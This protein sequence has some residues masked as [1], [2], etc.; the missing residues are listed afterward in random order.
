[1]NLSKQ[2]QLRRS[3][4]L[5]FAVGAVFAL[6]THAAEEGKKEK[7]TVELNKVEVTG[8]R[9]RRVDKEKA[10]PVFTMTRA[11]IEKSSAV[12][13]GQLLQ[14]MPSISGAATNPQVNN[15]GGTGGATVSLRG[16][17]S[18]R[19]LILLDGRRLVTTDVNAIPVNLIERVE[20][21]KDG[22]SAIYGADAVAGV[23]NFITRKNY[24]GA[25]LGS[26]YGIHQ[27]KDGEL[28]SLFATY[29]VTG[30]K[31]SIMVGASF[32]DREGVS[33][34]DRELPS[35]PR[36]LYYGQEVA[37]GSS[38]V[39]NGRYVVSCASAMAAGIVTT[40]PVTATNPNPTTALIRRDGAAGNAFNAA[41]FR[42]FVGGGP[43]NDTFN[44]QPDNLVLTPQQ[45]FGTFFKADYDMWNDASI[46]GINL[47]SAKVYTDALYHNTQS[48]F[49]IA[50]APFDGRPAFDNVPIS[51]QSV[52]NPF[53]QTIT[54][55]RLRLNSVGR[56]QEFFDINRLQ[57][58]VGSK[59]TIADNFDWEI[60]HTF[61]RENFNSQSR[62]D[63]FTGGLRTALGPSFIAADG[64]PTCGTPSAPIS[65]CTPINFVGIPDPAA[66][67]TVAPI[68]KFA[69]ESRLRNTVFNVANSDL[70]KLP[71][72]SV[73]AA[74][75]MEFRTV[76]LRE[77]PDFLR[78]NGLVSGNAQSPIQ[79]AFDVKEY[80][81]EVNVPVLAN[82]PFAKSLDLN[83]GVRVSD[84]SNFGETTNA[85]FGFEYRPY[86]DLLIRGTYADV[87]RA[88]TV[89]DLFSG[90]NDSADSAVDP[91]NGLTAATVA[92]NP[93]AARA[94]QNVRTDGTF[95]Q[96]DSQLPARTGGNP[97]LKPE[98]GDTQTVGFVYSPSF[99]PKVT[100]IMDYW[101]FN[102][103]DTIDTPGTENIL[104]AC[105][106]AGQFCDAIT[107]DGGGDVSNV[108]N[109]ISNIGET[110]TSGIDTSIAWNIGKV[111]FGT[112]N[113]GNFNYK[114]DTTY[115]MK[116]KNQ[117]VV[118]VPETLQDVPGKFIEASAGGLGN[119]A[120]VR[121]QQALT[122]RNGD[123]SARYVT[124]YI[125]AVNENPGD[126]GFDPSAPC[127]GNVQASGAV[128]ERKVERMFYHDIS[129]SYAFKPA[130]AELTFGIDNVANEPAPLVYSGF[131]GST[132][133]RTYNTTGRFYYGKV[134]FSFK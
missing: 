68:T 134:K 29:G 53:G 66:L 78:V 63:V 118:G 110:T 100:L 43:G 88:P 90:Q 59:G 25:E 133:A 89:A 127:I 61:G 93:N 83:A 76:D 1:M 39:P 26:S 121:A 129:T 104:N 3:I 108:F 7:K 117:Q 97:N 64:T 132:D 124:R 46:A 17:G 40:C 123:F 45:R 98:T 34:G 6:P 87:F 96:S 70:I 71:A 67:A 11:D 130:K 79:G 51:A 13:L 42:P 122:W 16:L 82:V 60:F 10:A 69:S 105:F 20:V 19:T 91:C 128:C 120:R 4:Y 107:R 86:D 14:E 103:E 114:L 47:G 31:G 37:F 15:G 30:E 52:F 27:R 54:D 113:V 77:T 80:F 33:A 49:Q 57:I 73:G 18:A 23:V 55:S 35:I 109:T 99:Y 72:G 95:R 85:K 22:A 28:K 125:S 126:L 116:Y 32:D 9:I 62:G 24:Q 58:T 112:F 12:T 41:N 75:G 5:A 131:N 48:N 56:R 101:R 119:F 92:A 115:L 38:R 94:C 8:S 102:L 44:F 21:L 106:N 111:A 81:A 74:V 36:S 50:A 65:G 84:Y 2:G